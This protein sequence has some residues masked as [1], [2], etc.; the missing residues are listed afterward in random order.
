M[1]EP[2]RYKLYYDRL[3]ADPEKRWVRREAQRKWRVDNAALL[4]ARQQDR[5]KRGLWKPDPEKQRTRHALQNAV[6]D[7][8]II[9]PDSCQDC[10][11]KGRIHGHHEDYSK[12]FDVAWV[13]ARCHGLRHRKPPM[14]ASK[15]EK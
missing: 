5:A 8:K 7:G 1:A 4:A 12:P 14:A 11:A 10:G 15:E 2:S 6:R 9:K 13:C 3:M